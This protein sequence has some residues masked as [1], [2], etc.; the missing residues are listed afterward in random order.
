MLKDI[1]KRIFV[2]LLAAALVLGSFSMA[3]AGQNTA[4]SSESSGQPAESAEPENSSGGK[5]SSEKTELYTMM[6]LIA[7]AAMYVGIR[8]KRR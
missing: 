7:L 8:G 6:G 1:S 2:L 4:P 5:V 3:F